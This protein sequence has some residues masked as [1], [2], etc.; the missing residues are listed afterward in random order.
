MRQGGP[1]LK[2]SLAIYMQNHLE[3][4]LPARDA[5]NQVLVLYD[6]HKSHV[7][8]GLIE[9]AKEN[10]IILFVLPPHCSHLLQPKDV[11]CYGPF[12][13]AWNAACH[14]HIRLSGGIAVTRYDVCRIASK[15]YTAA[16]SPVNIQSAFKRCGIY[17]FNDTV[18]SDNI[19]APSL[20]FAQVNTNSTPEKQNDIRQ[21]YPNDSAVTFLDK[22]GGE[23]LQNVK[24]AKVRK[25]LSKVVGGK[26]ITEDVVFD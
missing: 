19:I 9:W 6:G 12:E 18:I 17:P 23:V 14:Q 13:N 22:R 20:S 26:P 21:D 1:T 10:N 11:S 2:F 15:V 4:L 25:T 8:L 24:V 7:T 3:P 5:N 16:L